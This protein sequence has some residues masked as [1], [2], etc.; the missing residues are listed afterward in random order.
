MTPQVSLELDF[1]S[2]IAGVAT[3]L[4]MIPLQA[5][6]VRYIG[7]LRCGLLTTTHAQDD[8]TT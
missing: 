2:A 4:A 6:L 5:A 8:R 1:V 7:G 3:S